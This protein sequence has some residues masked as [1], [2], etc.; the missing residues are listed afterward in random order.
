MEVL[1][2]SIEDTFARVEFYPDDTIERVRELIAIDR[3]SHPD[4]L[5][6]QLRVTL[7]EGYYR[8][9][10]EWTDLFFRLSRDGQTVSK[11]VLE[12]YLTDVRPGVTFPRQPY[13]REQ[14]E[15][16]SIESAIR[17][18]GQEWHILG[19]KIQT[20][21]PR[22]PK[23]VALP[24]NAIPL[25]SL[26]SLFETIHPF[27]PSELRVTELP[28][29]PSDSV[30]RAYFPRFQPETPPN[31][32]TSKTAILKAQS[33]LAALMALVKPS[34]QHRTETVTRAK[35]YIPLNATSI[36]TPRTTFEQMFYGLTVSEETPCILYFTSEGNALRSKYYVE[37]STSKVPLLDPALVK[38]WYNATTPNRTR[39]TLL[40][41]RKG[42][43]GGQS[44]SRTV[45]Q[46]IA[47]TSSDI[48]IDI[49]KD[50]TSTKTKDELRVEG[51]EWLLSLD[52]IAP[53]LDPR[54]LSPDRWDLADLSLHASYAKEETEFDMLRFPCLQTLFG[55]QAGTF[56]LLRSEQGD[57]PRRVVDACQALT[58]EGATPTA[59]YL[60]TELGTSTEEASSLLESITSGD[61]NCDRS[62]RDFPTITFHRKDVDIQFAT[63]IDR[64]LDYVDILRYVLTANTD[65]V[66]A[67]C[68]RRKE[69][70]GPTAVVPQEAVVEDE[71]DEGGEDILAML[72][73]SNAAAAPPPE[74][75]VKPSRMLKVAQDQKTTQNYFNERLKA[76][77]AKLFGAPYARECEKNSQV[78][79]LTPEAKE[80]IR[81]EKGAEY[82]YEDA[83]AEE[84]MDIP[85]GTAICPPYWCMTDQIPLREDQL[86]EGTDGAMHCPVCKG[87]VRPNDK[88]STKEFPVIKRETSKGKISK[89]PRPMQKHDGVPCCYPT[90][91]KEAVVLNSRLEVTY[92]LTEELRDIP[93]KRVARL[94][95]DLASRLGVKT[96]YD[97]TIVKGRLEFQKE[98]V[99]RIGLGPR[100]RDTLPGTLVPAKPIQSPKEKPDIVRRCSFFSTLRSAD[101]IE[102]AERKW[103]DGTLDPLDEVEYLSF[104]L[105]FNV[106][107][108]AMDRFKVLCGFQTQDILAR[109]QTLVVLLRSGGHPEVLG[110]MRRKRKG[111][112]GETIYNVNIV[113]A[114]L[115]AMT[116]KLVQAHQEACAGDLPTLADALVAVRELGR[117]D[118]YTGVTDPTGRLQGLLVPGRALIPCVPTTQTLATRVPLKMLHEIPDEDLPTYADEVAALNSLKAERLFRHEPSKDRRNAAG[119]LV[120]VETVTGFRVLVRPSAPPSAGP[121][122]EVF[123]TVR[124]ATGFDASGNALRGEQVLVSGVAD[125]DGRTEKDKIDY[126][127]EL[128]EFLLFSLANDIAPAVDDEARDVN[129]MALRRAIDRKDT[130]SLGRLL[131]DWYGREAYE[132]TTK[133]TYKFISKVRKPCGQMTDEP[134]CSKS[135]L[136]GWD[137]NDCKVQVQTSRVTSAELLE[138]IQTILL[139]NDKQRALVLDNRL[140]RF[141]STVLYL[142][143]PHETIRVG[144]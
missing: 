42:P 17:D 116:T 113:T 70:V 95:P 54:D 12:T 58:R 50:K 35:W 65:D 41:Y 78:V 24:T 97:S 76:F 31:L 86:E 32:D 72:D 123:E 43:K 110:T 129:Y 87:K 62:L 140:S 27:P 40:L 126:R 56:R 132:E 59:A 93:A 66:N 89:Y 134:T 44:A 28:T 142:E 122:A 14:W 115:D 73:L 38:A 103:Q 48:T 49:R 15:A 84:Q 8:T 4:R 9:P 96:K 104:L 75:V 47:I 105:E 61:I 136:C 144:I 60:A 82:T 90:P 108:V 63:T 81:A 109:G 67:V 120:E 121:V 88:V 124:A 119:L 19:A 130:A 64:T 10:R 138:Q 21:L 37:N 30:L 135:S 51:E 94:S 2:L 36:A 71:V 53:S 102:E 139:T 39:P 55:H 7:P 68:P 131:A 5:F 25:L 3:N 114:P 83:P 106:I 143:M 117:L 11:E 57:I 125:P 69:M 33:D 112:G 111:A 29:D 20:V 127:S 34:M 16:V 45:F 107:L 133:T 18:G 22:P 100:P 52:A 46:R 98:D 101:P 80:V 77:D 26:Q 85:N 6:I 91:A 13:T 128:V 99:F 74:P 92:V 79:V 1:K 137:K 141:F 118:S 23:D